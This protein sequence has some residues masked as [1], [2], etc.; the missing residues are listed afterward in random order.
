MIMFV[1]F[2]RWIEIP[3]VVVSTH[4]DAPSSV[5][6]GGLL[7]AMR[8]LTYQRH[9]R[10]SIVTAGGS[11]VLMMLLFSFKFSP[12][13]SEKLKSKERFGLAYDIWMQDDARTGL[14]YSINRC[15]LQT[16]GFLG[17]SAYW[18][19]L[20]LQ[21][22]TMEI[23]VNIHGSD[24][25]NWPSAKAQLKQL[26]LISHSPSRSKPNLRKM[27]T[28]EINLSTAF[29]SIF[30]EDFLGLQNFFHRKSWENWS[31]HVQ[32]HPLRADFPTWICL[33]TGLPSEIPNLPGADAAN[34]TV[35]FVGFHEISRRNTWFFCSCW[36]IIKS[37]L[38]WIAKS[39]V[40]CS[41]LP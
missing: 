4:L 31:K 41:T 27:E 12:E 10:I 19:K 26:R 28:I 17:W 40:F 38:F 2:C 13:K 7:A 22:L 20:Q 35:D 37:H 34:P 11:S 21:F 16:L 8:L 23:S 14:K 15:K 24:K 29:H 6:L 33:D 25:N 30:P 9:W 18:K 39:R 5:V 36:Y 1:G 3:L 32:T